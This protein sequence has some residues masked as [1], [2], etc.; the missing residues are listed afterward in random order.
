VIGW[1]AGKEVRSELAKLSPSGMTAMFDQHF[2]KHPIAV[3]DRRHD[4][5]G[6]LADLNIDATVPAD[7]S[8]PF[9][10]PLPKRPSRQEIRAEVEAAMAYEREPPTALAAE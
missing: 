3:F 4:G 10:P 9:L 2:L 6:A 7:L 1:R 8:E 5:V